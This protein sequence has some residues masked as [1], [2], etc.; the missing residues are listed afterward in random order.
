MNFCKEEVHQYK[1]V[2]SHLN[3]IGTQTR[4]D[5]SFDVDSLRT[6]FGKCAIE[7]LLET[8]KVITRVKTDQ[9]SSFFSLINGNIHLECYSGESSAF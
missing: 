6:R 4:P 2:A 1:S 9:V 8:N 5:L 3:W 7:D